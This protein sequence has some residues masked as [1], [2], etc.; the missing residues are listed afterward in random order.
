M[1]SETE[2]R[3]SVA[4]VEDRRLEC[5]RLP[6]AILTLGAATLEVGAEEEDK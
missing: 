1:W 6:W 2:S 5:C 3:D 4:G